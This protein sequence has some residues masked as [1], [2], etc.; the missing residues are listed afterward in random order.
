MDAISRFLALERFLLRMATKA[1]AAWL[2]SDGM[3]FMRKL[4]GEN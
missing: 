4:Y 1:L 2:I 3:V